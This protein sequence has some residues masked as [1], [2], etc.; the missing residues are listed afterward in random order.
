MKNNAEIIVLHLSLIDG[1]G[2][3]TVERILNNLSPES[4]ADIYQ[5]T[6]SDCMARFGLNQKNA[7]I[8]VKGL[9]DASMLEKELAHIE[10]SKI[11]WVSILDHAYPELLKTIHIPPTV[12]YWRGTLPGSQ[13]IAIVGSRGANA[14]GR[15]AINRLVP[16]LVA[17]NFTIVSGG[18]QG[19]DT[20]A[21]Q[22]TLDV[23]G[24]TV[25]VL[26]SGLLVRLF[27]PQNIPLF[28]KIV[29]TGGALVSCFPL[30]KHAAAENFPI[31]NRIISGLSRGCIVIQAAAKS[32]ARITA[33]FTLSQGREVF[34]VP[35]PIDSELSE[36]CHELIAQGAKLITKAADVL[37][38]Y[39]IQ[40][41][42]PEPV[43]G[44]QKSVKK[45]GR[46]PPGQQ[47]IFTPAQLAVPID[48][49][50]AIILANCANPSAVDE[51]LEA[52][53]LPLIQL[54]KMLFEL[55]L[56]GVLA[57]NMAGLW[58]SFDPSSPSPSTNARE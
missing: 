50:E 42:H 32:G 23:G 5:F 16:E 15:M 20:M 45:Q 31:R 37:I 4:L 36:G 35:G 55:Q 24:K 53:G 47:P 27:P 56:K 6:A 8:L 51:L 54:S 38:E 12:I 26:G 28:E 17:H 1:I 43:E 9:A 22:K 41:I 48:P 30:M 3:A 46:K 11:Q 18:A 29:E 58:E 13:S 2:P 57:Q 39:G 44:P 34:A 10:R 25:A 33:D 52:T 21:H 19:A 40:V 14:Y 49:M 7:E